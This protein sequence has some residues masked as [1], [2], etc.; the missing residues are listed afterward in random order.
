MIQKYT[1]IDSDFFLIG[2]AVL[3]LIFLILLIVQTVRI[4]K[5][6][7]R[8]ASFMKGKDG[9]S[10]EETLIH[11]LEQIDDVSRQNEENKRNIKK[12]NA[13]MK[14]TFCRCG[15]VKYDAFNESGGKLSFVITLLDEK[16]DGF[17][18]NV[19]HAHDGSYSYIKDVVA[20]NPIVNLGTEEEES[21]EK[22]LTS[23]KEV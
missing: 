8:L 1:G 21:L 5:L 7:K 9:K 12:I 18:L 23:N 11:R 10:L 13:K 15:I 20:G 6:N 14:N 16:K 4:G 19:V 17:I 2:L 3:V 22:A